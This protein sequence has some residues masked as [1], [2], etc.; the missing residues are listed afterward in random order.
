MM[1][2]A[3]CRPALLRGDVAFHIKDLQPGGDADLLDLTSELGSS[4][5]SQREDRELDAG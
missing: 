2:E 4:H 5:V 3:L 1:V